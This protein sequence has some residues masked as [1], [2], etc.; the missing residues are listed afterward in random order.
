MIIRVLFF[1]AFVAF[2]GNHFRVKKT[3]RVKTTANSAI[4][5]T[6]SVV[7]MVGSETSAGAETHLTDT[8]RISGDFV[9]F[10]RP[11]S[12]RFEEYAMDSESGIYEADSDFGVAISAT[13]DGLYGHKK[14]K[15][16]QTDV[17][18]KR[19]ILIED[20]KNAPLIIDRDT[21]DFG[22]IMTS[23]GKAIKIITFLHSGDYLSDVDEYFD[24]K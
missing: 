21:T 2:G 15:R 18:E 4:A 6:N 11:D 12:I 8:I 16:L 17:T 24:V 3:T 13:M 1:L 19:Y 20:C 22:L 9:L 7:Q 14:Y 10:L 5:G 23:K